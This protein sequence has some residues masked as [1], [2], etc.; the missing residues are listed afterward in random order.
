MSIDDERIRLVR[1]MGKVLIKMN[2][3]QFGT[4]RLTSGKLSSYYINLRLV[5]SLPDVFKETINAYLYAIK[6]ELSTRGFDA[7]C[8]IATSGLTFASCIAYALSK[9]LVYTRREKKE[10]G[11]SKKLEGAL[12]PG[13]RVLIVDDLATT[14]ESILSAADAVKSE[15]GK[16]ENAVVL[17]DRNEG[18][19]SALAKEGVKLYAF[20]DIA[21][22]SEIL[23]DAGLLEQEQ[24]EAIRK[25]MRGA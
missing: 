21:E 24:I 7:L 22:L 2:A 5:P 19:K 11:L 10:H 14:G 23:F 1:N 12:Y 15:G 25:Q 4:F 18:A 16:V 13:W 20:T 3:I 17:I 9:P 8:G 6:R